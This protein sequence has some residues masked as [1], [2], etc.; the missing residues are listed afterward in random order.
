MF[1]NIMIHPCHSWDGLKKI[2]MIAVTAAIIP[3]IPVMIVLTRG[4]A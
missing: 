3:P 1:T 4:N 2:P